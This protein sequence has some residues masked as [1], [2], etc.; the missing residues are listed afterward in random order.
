[1]E[2]LYFQI[3]EEINLE[4]YDLEINVLLIKY[5]ETNQ[6]FLNLNMMTLNW[7]FIFINPQRSIKICPLC[8]KGKDSS[9]EAAILGSTIW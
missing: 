6:V 4:D 3:E 1:M 2:Y 5:S 9:R 7:I 8:F